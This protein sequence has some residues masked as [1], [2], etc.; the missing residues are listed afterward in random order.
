VQDGVALS[1][2]ATQC[3]SAQPAAATTQFVG[4]GECHT[5]ARHAERVTDGNRAT[6]DVHHIGV[7]AEL[8]HRGQTDGGE[9]LVEFEQRHVRHRLP[10]GL[11][12]GEDGSRRLGKQRR[13]GPGDLPVPHDAG[14][15]GGAETCGHGFGH[16]DHRGA[17]VGDLR[18][19]AGGDVAGLVERRAQFGQ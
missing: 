4:Q 10:G 8:G 3:R 13:V 15:R 6:V 19:V 12:G 17:A 1:G 16:H 14:Q 18:R 11:K 5:G 7:D 2:A 9:R